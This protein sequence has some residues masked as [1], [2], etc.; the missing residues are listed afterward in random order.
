MRQT[1]RTT[2]DGKSNA[3]SKR[4]PVPV[5]GVLPYLENKAIILCLPRLNTP[6]KL[7]VF[8]LCIKVCLNCSTI[9]NLGSEADNLLSLSGSACLLLA[10]CTRRYTPKAA[11]LHAALLLTAFYTAWTAKNFTILIT[12]LSGLAIYRE[13]A[14]VLLDILW[15]TE[16]SYLAIQLFS[17]CFLAAVSDFALGRLFSGGTIRYTFGFTHPNLL[18]LFLCN[19]LLIWCYRHYAQIDTRHFIGILAAAGSIYLFTKT[20]TALIA[21]VLFVLLLIWQKK[22][23]SKKNRLL[24]AAAA[25]LPVVLCLLTVVSAA[26]Y[27]KSSLILQLDDWL[28]GRLKLA[29]YAYDHYG[30]TMFGQDLTDRTVRW[31]P[32][33]RLNGHT[34]DNAYAFLGINLGSIW[35]IIL[36]ACALWLGLRG[37]KKALPF[38]ILWAFYSFTEVNALNAYL[39][40]P[41]LL[42]VLTT[43]AP[44]AAPKNQTTRA[45]TERKD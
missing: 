7:G 39:L 22:S 13:D 4:A 42:P 6:V 36:L 2:I 25:I 11:L 27:M 21:E 16:L 45:I 38:F 20:R 15:K 35:L 41:V 10:I 29:A 43:P 3:I 37:P 30:V 31:D 44:N 26:F 17:A 14:D 23:K 32:V 1:I 28:S 33:W 9:F 18:S 24:S 8:L 19:L 5:S 40:F 12:V 34:F